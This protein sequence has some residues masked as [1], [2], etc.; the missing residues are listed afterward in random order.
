MPFRLLQYLAIIHI[1]NVREHVHDSCVGE[2]R[3]KCDYIRQTYAICLLH[4][5]FM[6]AVCIYL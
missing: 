1:A 5:W 4:I 3:R 6:Y 2:M